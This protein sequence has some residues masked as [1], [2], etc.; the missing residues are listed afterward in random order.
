MKGVA[1]ASFHQDNERVVG[2][3]DGTLAGAIRFSS[4]RFNASAGFVNL[5]QPVATIRRVRYPQQ[6]RRSRAGLDS[7]IRNVVTKMQSVS[8]EL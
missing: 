4:F 2:V 7:H 5:S 3:H 8:T 1:G 6:M